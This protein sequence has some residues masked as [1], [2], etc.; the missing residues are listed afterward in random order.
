MDTRKRLGCHDNE[1]SAGY[2]KTQKLT[3][4]LR[5]NTR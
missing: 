3:G 5:Q 4:I 1:I 2:D